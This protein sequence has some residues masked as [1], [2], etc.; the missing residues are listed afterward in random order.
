MPDFHTH[1][2]ACAQCADHP[3]ALCAAGAALLEQAAERGRFAMGEGSDRAWLE[4]GVRLACFCS[5]PG[6]HLGCDCI[7]DITGA[8]YSAQVW[9]PCFCH[10]P[11]SGTD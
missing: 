9:C 5:K 4:R 7:A 11:V 2:D 6:R 10:L 1:L 8:P 3:F